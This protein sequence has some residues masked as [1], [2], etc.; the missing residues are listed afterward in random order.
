MTLQQ[1]VDA[2][3]AQVTDAGRRAALF[4]GGVIPPGFFT[5]GAYNLGDCPEIDQ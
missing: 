1:F 2:F 4:G 5:G 3:R